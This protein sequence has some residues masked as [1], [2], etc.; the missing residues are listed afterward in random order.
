MAVKVIEGKFN[1]PVGRYGIVVSRWNNFITD[2]LKDGALDTFR[3]HGISDEH[4]TVAY[5]PG[6]YEIPLT[7]QTM[8]ET[9]KYDAI[10][11]IGVVIRGATAHFDFVAGTANNGVLQTNLKTGVPIIFGVL[12]TDTIEQSVERAGTK[13]GNKGE[14]AAL[15]AIEMVSLLKQ[16][17]SV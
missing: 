17:K 15:V 13:S 14:E 6:A 16:L 12:T 11:A 3:R 7:A 2:K 4:I 8:A 9:G 5:C 10:L 1:E